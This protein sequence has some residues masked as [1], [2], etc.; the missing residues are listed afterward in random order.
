MNRLAKITLIAL[1]VISLVMTV[2]Y[3]LN[4]EGDNLE[5]WTYAFLNWAYIMLALAIVLII[6]LPFLTIRQRKINYKSVIFTIVGIVVVL[7]G[8]YLLAPATPVVL[9]TG[10]VHEGP[11]VKLTETG[12]IVTYFLIAVAFLSIIGGAVYNGLRKN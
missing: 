8:A 9:A 6:V 4:T 5:G 7:G 12:L 10:A 11:A 2:L 3:F 1:M